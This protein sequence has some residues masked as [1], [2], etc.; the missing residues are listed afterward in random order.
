[1]TTKDIGDIG[2]C[3]A[4]KF[5]KKNGY[6]IVGRNVH[7]SHNEIDI[8][9]EDKEFIV[10]VEVKTRT[11]SSGGENLYGVPSSAVTY[12][13]QKRL[14]CAARDYLR[15]N[16]TCKQPRMDVIEIW[17]D[18]SKKLLDLNHIRNAYGG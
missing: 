16:R 4:A 12:A 6:K 18:D 1:M 14:L 10:F 15:E 8:I 9:A 7:M 2:E 5:L 13:K 17:L 3:A 11:K